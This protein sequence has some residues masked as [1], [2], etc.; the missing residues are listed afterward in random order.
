MSKRN[1]PS[2]SSRPASFASFRPFS[3]R[4]T[5]VQPVNRFSLF[6]VLSPWRSR[7]ILYMAFP[8]LS[9]TPGGP[10]ETRTLCARQGS[11]GLAPGVAGALAELLLDAQQ[12]VVLAHA[13]GAAGRAG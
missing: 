6:H 7:T 2:F 12:L 3:D 8:I 10:G 1:P 9:S 4:S 5:S 13:I 11:D